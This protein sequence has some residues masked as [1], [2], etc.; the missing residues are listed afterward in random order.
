[1]IIA[2]LV[3][4]AITAW[5][6]GLRPGLWAAVGTALLCLAAVFVPRY[7]LHIYVGLSVAVVGVIIVGQRRP[8]PPDTV[9]AWRFVSGRVKSFLARGDKDK[10]KKGR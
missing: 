9:L 5:Y 4:G 6:F 8:R 3:V 2:A 7:A 1:M 10:A